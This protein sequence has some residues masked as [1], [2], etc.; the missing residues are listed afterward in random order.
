MRILALVLCLSLVAPMLMI[1]LPVQA[2]TDT[3]GI[4]TYVSDFGFAGKT[5]SILGDSISTFEDYSSGTAANTTNS[6]IANNAVYYRPS[7]Y[8]SYGVAVND[9]WWK[10]TADVLGMR[11]LVNNSWSGS[12]VL[13]TNESAGYLTR[14][15]QLHD[16]T[17]SNSG[18]TPDVIVIYLGTNDVKNGD[19]PGNVSAINYTTL[20]NASS[21]YTPSTVLEAY[22]LMVYRAM[23]KYPNAEIYCMTLIPQKTATAD[24]NNT[25]MKFNDGVRQIVKHYGVNLVDL[26]Y[27]SGV[28]AMPENFD[29]HLANWLHPGPYGMDAITNCLVSAL[30]TN[31]QHNTSGKTLR[32]VSYDLNDVFVK[33]GSVKVAVDGKPLK[34][35]LGTRNG[36]GMDVQVTMGGVDITEQCYS[37]GVISIDSVN[38]DIQVKAIRS[39]D[40]KAP[41]I[42]RWELTSNA[43]RSVNDGGAIYNYAT[44]TAGSCSSNV[45]T[46]AQHSLDKPVV[47]FHNRPWVVEWKSSGDWTGHVLMMAGS[48]ASKT[49]DSTY[50]YR[51]PGSDL[52][53][54]GYCDGSSYHN[55]GVN[56]ADHGINGSTTHTYRL[57]NQVNADGSNMVY[58]HVDGK[59]LGA[60]NNYYLAGSNQNQV[61][62]WVNGQDF[63]F[64][65][66]G[67][68]G[69]PISGCTINHIQAWEN[70][71]PQETTLN[72][73][74][75]E[76]G[77]GTLTSI[78]GAGYVS[79]AA[80]LVTGSV[81]TAGKFSGSYFTL[82]K[83]V[84]L[85]HNKPWSLEWKASGTWKDSAN[86]AMLF[87]AS[88]ISNAPYG[89]F[90][91]NRSNGELLAFGERNGS[92]HTNYGICLVD[93]GIDVTLEHTYRLTNRINGD[94]TNM[95]YLYV[96][97][98]ELGAMNNYYV[99]A[100]AQGTTSNWVSGRDFT[101]TQIGN[102][103][104][105]VGNCNL[106]Y[107]QVWEDGLTPNDYRWEM[108]GDTLTSITS[109]T[110]INNDLTTL[111][112]SISDGKLS[113]VQMKTEQNIVLRHDRTWTLEW[114]S[115]GTW[116][117][118]SN[119][120]IFLST[121]PTSTADGTY[122]LYR[123]GGSDLIALGNRTGG[124]HINYGVSLADHGIDGTV[125]HVYRLV[126]RVNAD[127]TNMVYLYVD[128][129]EL[130]AMNNYYS[131]GTAQ[132]TT[133]NWVSG[134]DFHFAYIGTTDFPV[135]NCSLDYIQV[136]EGTVVRNE[137]RW[138]GGDSSLDSITSDNLTQNNVT[139]LG[140]SITD[141]V[142]N[143]S[144]YQL[145]KSV[146]LLHSQPWFIEWQSEGSWNSSTGGALLL[147]SEASSK[148]NG[149][150]YI[151]RRKDSSLI[152]LGINNNNKFENY[153]FKLSDYGIDASAAHVYRMV[154]RL[155]GDGTNM[156]YLY[157]DG[158]EIGPMN[159]YFLGGS[160]QGTTSNA[161]SGMDFTFNYM[162]SD[163]HLIGN[164]T[165]GYIHVDENGKDPESFRWETQSDVFVNV[166]DEKND[167]N[168]VAMESGS[169]SAGQF[170]GAYFSLEQP[171][172]LMHNQPWIVEWKSSGRW[173]DTQNGGMLLSSTPNSGVA[174]M[175]YLFRRA[176]SDFICI[177]A[178]LNN[179]HMNYGIR[180][181]EYGID[182]TVSHTYAFINRIREDGSNMIYLYVDGVEVG[183]LNN[184]YIG[185]TDSYT[186][187]EWLS[188]KDF[189]F[190][191]L[192]NSGFPISN[193]KLDYLQ[194]W[195]GGMTGL[196]QFVNWNGTVLSKQE[197]YYG[198]AVLAPEQPVREST[199]TATYTFAGWDKTVDVCKGDTVYTATYTEHLIEYTVVF[200]NYDGTVLSSEIYH[201]GDTV[202]A[203]AAPKR[204]ADE[205]YAYTFAGWDKTVDVCT[206]DT[207]Y[208]ATYTEH[209]IE[210]TVVFKNYDGTVLSSE[211]YHYGDTVKAPAAPK[212]EA[213]ETYAYTFAGWDKTVDVCT[214]DATYTAVYEKTVVAKPQIT[215]SHP[216]L[217]FESEIMYNVYYTAN[218]LEDAV[219]MGLV[220]FTEPNTDG[221]V[222]DAVEVVSGYVWNGQNYMVH[223]SGIPAKNLGDT[224]Y[225]KVYARM[226]D[227]TYIYSEMAGYN[228]I[229]YANSILSNAA[230]TA[231]MKGLV[232]AM[233]NY[234]AEAQRYFGHNTDKLMNAGLTEAQQAMVRGYDPS[235]LDDVAPTDSDKH[236]G[237][238]MNK[239]AFS[240]AYPSISFEGALDINYYIVNALPVDG[241][242]TL[243]YWNRTDYEN[244]DRLLVGNATGSM[245]MTYDGS[246]Y[247]GIVEGIAAKEMDQTIYTTAVYV[248]GGVTYTTGIIAYSIG[249]YCEGLAANDNADAQQLAA[250]AAVYG[251]YA[252]TYFASIA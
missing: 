247:H 203:P 144:Y 131:G 95:V 68:D 197:Y 7:N 108:Q 207:V 217:N 61:V 42:Y 36:F 230:S 56:L 169:I 49:A 66:M 137:F 214:G 142:F 172:T 165:I 76:P 237:F 185:A 112:G 158:E 148:T 111:T 193:C 124:K 251:Y 184:Q 14:C 239:T 31:S 242:M 119:G 115:S 155:N 252:K 221:T 35:P 166:T 241:E 71:I 20:K 127:G 235:M 86:G 163:D 240:A 162:G 22:A 206:G 135:G 79:N 51:R 90:I 63:V 87:S 180:L 78:S 73:Y 177:G 65:N 183:P 5:I 8:S 34:L 190:S 19:D 40:N 117:D 93:H 232:V 102:Q 16:N 39:V 143:D 103:Q 138:E 100:T 82:E 27:D 12:R 152:A 101:F 33:Q 47:L 80:N 2:A 191:Y 21:S 200:K 213:D 204:E 156:V 43:L 223:T 246:R 249:T 30:L 159:Q 89:A 77:N 41:E 118:S 168:K 199:E 28:T 250:G 134:K 60:M 196:V 94:G 202:K 234:G 132:G 64:T 110:Y 245:T 114:Q 176:D 218:D 26:Y 136:N 140:G 228:A 179:Q 139:T 164:C 181:S 23:K 205:T 215:L 198:D 83:P 122:Y 151:F 175:S 109:D 161:L 233:L 174:G 3:G 25:Y 84:V 153:G 141:G 149:C 24:V 81:S 130:G 9:T 212:R 67:T 48:A 72:D 182:G 70:G 167:A 116:K 37:N 171:I 147:S 106:S 45:F 154:N 236:G 146:V 224:V 225:F 248:S 50:I 58:L 15:Q 44:L 113:Q 192:G 121:D 188:G 96:D 187:S 52:I 18:E 220:M 32:S 209:L 104:F 105:P 160:A 62:D 211:I 6:T 92:S 57:V 55:Y 229:A 107:V 91:Y 123:R 227:G 74:R 231:E 4:S 208:T 29:Y 10:Q 186:K 178:R 53:A 173:L 226:A 69:H 99:S 222:A 98:V 1:Q 11:V 133:S 189:T 88:N 238:V 210:Y 13:Y 46:S 120:A 157:V 17:G 194:I 201:Y 150:S 126:N 244:A 75:W 54:L 170:S 128:D 85:L 216:T 145:E 97:G 243:Y 219:E 59:N 125:K 38:G 129:V 195:E